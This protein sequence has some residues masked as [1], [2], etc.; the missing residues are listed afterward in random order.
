[1]ILPGYEGTDEEF[2]KTF[3][4]YQSEKDFSGAPPE[5]IAYACTRWIRFVKESSK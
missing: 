2:I 4:R 5:F 1:M 3:G